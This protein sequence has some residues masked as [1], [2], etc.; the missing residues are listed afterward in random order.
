[1]QLTNAQNVGEDIQRNRVY[2]PLDE[3]ESNGITESE[4]NGDVVLNKT[5]S[6]A[7]PLCKEGQ[8]LPCRGK[9]ALPLL[10]RRTRYSPAAMIAF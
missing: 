10:P 6:H 8:N 5:W 4:L 9:A 3:L 2:L 7:P 1:M